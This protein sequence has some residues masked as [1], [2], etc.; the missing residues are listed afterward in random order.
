M[1]F[2]GLRKEIRDIYQS[3]AI[4]RSLVTKNLFGRY[5]NSFLGF[6]WHFVMPIVMIL[7]YYIAFTEIRTSSIPD[8]WVFIASGIFPFNFM[9]SNLTGGAGAVVSNSGLVKKMYFPREILVFAHVISNF[10]V[11]V[12]GYSIILVAIFISGYGFNLSALAVLPLLL[13]VMAMFSMGCALLFS[14]LTVYVRDIQYTLMSISMVFFFLTPMYFM[15][16]DATG[17][18]S[19]IIWMNPFTY[20]VESFHSIVYLET[21]PDVGILMMCLLISIVSFAIGYAAFARLKK[22]FAERL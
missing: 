15:G 9:L 6:G 4:L 11:M 19:R 21:I 5:R 22:G 1:V 18:L 12:I 13:I 20:F 8:F 7:V 16:S 2:G 10:I 14:S 3:R 17:I